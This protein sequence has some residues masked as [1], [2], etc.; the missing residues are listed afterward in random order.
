LQRDCRSLGVLI[1]QKVRHRLEKEIEEE[2]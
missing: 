2:Q 1:I